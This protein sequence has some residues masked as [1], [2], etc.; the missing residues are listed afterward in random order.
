MSDDVFPDRNMEH[1][2]KLAWVIEDQGWVA[3]PVDP[4]EG[5]P[6][7]AGYTYSIGFEDFESS[8][9]LLPAKADPY[10]L[11]IKFWRIPRVTCPYF[12]FEAVIRDTE[13]VV[14]GQTASSSYKPAKLEN[15]VRV[16]VPPHVE[17]GTKIVVRTADSEYMER[18]KD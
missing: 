10:L 8:L 1:L 14:K 16:M 2:D 5:P 4:V 15:G 3:D 13:A 18:A 6:P 17:S 9:F 12:R 7:Q 11:A